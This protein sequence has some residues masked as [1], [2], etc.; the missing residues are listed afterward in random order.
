MFN[1][2]EFL[3]CH[4]KEWGEGKSVWSYRIAVQSRIDGC[5]RAKKITKYSSLLF[6]RA[7][8]ARLTQ[9]RIYLYNF[10]YYYLLLLP[11]LLYTAVSNNNSSAWPRKKRSKSAS[12]HVYTTSRHITD[13]IRTKVI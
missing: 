6:G 12:L 13:R 5:R 11:L 8:T 10:Y 9:F 7:T 1:A 3:D 4:A 2:I